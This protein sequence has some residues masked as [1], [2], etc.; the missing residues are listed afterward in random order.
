V[1]IY[2]VTAVTSFDFLKYYW[3]LI[4]KSNDADPDL[5]LPWHGISFPA[6]H[7]ACPGPFEKAIDSIGKEWYKKK[8][9]ECLRT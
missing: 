4:T 2:H 6:L 8:E 1:L 5:G 3:T 7:A 9:I